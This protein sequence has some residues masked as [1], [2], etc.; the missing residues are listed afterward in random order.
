MRGSFS[1]IRPSAQRLCWGHVWI[2]TPSIRANLVSFDCPTSYER[3]RDLYFKLGITQGYYHIPVH[4]CIDIWWR[5]F[6]P[7]SGN[8]LLNK[9]LKQTF[10]WRKKYFFLELYHR[11]HYKF[12]IKSLIFKIFFSGLFA[13]CL[14]LHIYIYRVRDRVASSVLN[15]VCDTYLHFWLHW[16]NSWKVVTYF[17]FIILK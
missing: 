1:L 12:V 11:F 4:Y 17:F 9:L 2:C 16:L 6:E 15:N 8:W 10:N 13:L 7:G 3:L 14:H 5:N